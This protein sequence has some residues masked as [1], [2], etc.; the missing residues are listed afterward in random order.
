[1]K[2]TA[3]ELIVKEAAKQAAR[4]AAD[5][6]EMN[7]VQ[8]IPLCDECAEIWETGDPL[9]DS[10]LHAMD[11]ADETEFDRIFERKFKAHLKAINKKSPVM[12]RV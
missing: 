4:D 3:K 11:T 9:S 1:M 8:D 12:T 6:L 5:V 7:G 10:C 2:L